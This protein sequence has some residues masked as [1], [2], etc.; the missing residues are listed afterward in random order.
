M[1]HGHLVNSSP[2]VDLLILTWSNQVMK[3]PYY[4]SWVAMLCGMSEEPGVAAPW[5]KINAINFDKCIS[6]KHSD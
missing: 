3:L 2:C 4:A 5:I 1:N 6:C